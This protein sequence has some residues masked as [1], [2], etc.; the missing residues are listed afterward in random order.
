MSDDINK[1]TSQHISEMLGGLLEKSIGQFQ[2]ELTETTKSIKELTRYVSNLERDMHHPPCADMT[3]L[4][5]ELDVRLEDIE[6]RMLEHREQ[7][8]RELAEYE[9]EQRDK[10]AFWRQVGVAVVAAAILF[11]LCLAVIGF[12]SGAHPSGVAVHGK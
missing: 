9:L 1:S 8:S 3:T 11:L 12:Q 7:H 2:H 4:R 5:A 10:K 6:R